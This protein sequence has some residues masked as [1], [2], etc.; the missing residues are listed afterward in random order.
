MIKENVEPFACPVLID[1][2]GTLTDDR[3]VPQ[4][5]PRHPLGNAL[6][7][8][9]VDELQAGGRRAEDAVRDLH[10]FTVE[11]VFWDYGDYIPHFGLDAARVWARFRA[12]HAEH[13]HAWPDGVAMVRALHRRGHP[14]HVISNNPL[15]GCLLKLEVAGLGS[16]TGSPWFGRIFASNLARGQKG[17]PEF[18]ARAL[19][20]ADLSP[21]RVVVVGNDR[22]ED[23]EVPRTLGVGRVFLVDRATPAPARPADGLT[24]VPS[25]EQVPALLAAEERI[26]A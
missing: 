16:L 21:D 8:I 23:Y 20:G 18:W 13:I 24:V 26:T 15:T 4:I 6:F 9:L 19:A 22:R 12:W 3:A 11:H 1:I 10:A 14:L 17:R 25:L 2:D 7:A 5:D